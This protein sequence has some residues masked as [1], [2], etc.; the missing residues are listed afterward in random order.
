MSREEAKKHLSII[1][2]RLDQIRQSL[3]AL[4]DGQAFVSFGCETNLDFC[5]KYL[6]GALDFYGASNDWPCW[7]DG[8][9]VV[10]W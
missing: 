3:Y 6:E 8:Q 1:Q 5:Q 9:S 10:E 7:D 2:S 4:Q